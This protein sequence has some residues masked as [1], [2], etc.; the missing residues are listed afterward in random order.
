M[1]N[2]ILAPTDGSGFD[3]D[4]LRVAARLSDAAGTELKLVRVWSAPMVFTG[5]DALIYPQEAITRE[6]EYEASRLESLKGEVA[7][8]TRA[9]V[10]ASLEEGPVADGI[11]RYAREENVD[12]IVISSH[13]RGGMARAAMGSVTDSLIRNTNIPVLVVKPS[14]S[15]LDNKDTALFRRILVPLDGS[16]LAE[17]I[18][19]HVA[20]IAKKYGA[21][22]VLQHVLTPLTY[23]Q[24]KMQD[25]QMPWWEDDIEVAQTYLAEQAEMMRKLGVPTTIEISIGESAADGITRAAGRLRADLIAIGT[26]GRGGIARVLRGSVADSVVRCSRTSMLVFHPAAHAVEKSAEPVRATEAVFAPAT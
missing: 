3:R 25:G 4:A 9:K 20:A 5:P 6:R 17:E 12:L 7:K 24:R 21:S 18:L 1:L 8:E 26:R 14:G 2:V 11:A 13:G 16:T 10:T 15:Y 23:S 19:P 22:V